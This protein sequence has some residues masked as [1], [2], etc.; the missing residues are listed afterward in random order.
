MRVGVSSERASPPIPTSRH[1]RQISPPSRAVVVPRASRR[2]SDAESCPSNDREISRVPR[3]RASASRAPD[4][5]TEETTYLGF[6]DVKERE[7]V[8]F[9]REYAEA[10]DRTTKALV[11]RARGREELGDPVAIARAGDLLRALLPDID[12]CSVFEREPG[13]VRLEFRDASKRVLAL[14]DVLCSS[15][16]CRDVTSLVERHP[17]LLLVDDIEAHIER[18]VAKLASL[19]PRCDARS[20]VSEFPELIY[21]IHSYDYV[22]S[23][24]ISIQN[25]LL[26]SASE[27]EARIDDYERA[28]NERERINRGDVDDPFDDQALDW[29]VDG[30]YEGPSHEGP[31]AD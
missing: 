28:W 7:L 9:W 25:M 22:E 18:A 27:D 23:L 12:V 21:R 11:E 4:A 8:T 2:R 17:T 6:D 31:I 5:R 13:A 19:E 26:D 16:L 1:A 14:Q 30:Y 15:D 3:A 10:N 29:T 24:P 20:I